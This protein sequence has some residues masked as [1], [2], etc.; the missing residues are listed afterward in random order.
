M[1]L[2]SLHSFNP[3]T[4]KLHHHSKLQLLKFSFK[5]PTTFLEKKIGKVLFDERFSSH[6]NLILFQMIFWSQFSICRKNRMNF[7]S[8]DFN[9]FWRDENS[10]EKWFLILVKFWIVFWEIF[11]GYPWVAVTGNKKRRSPEKSIKLMRCQ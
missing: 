11:G 4:A 5:I 3:K 2:P 10:I 6:D 8:V 1:I 7:L 9:L